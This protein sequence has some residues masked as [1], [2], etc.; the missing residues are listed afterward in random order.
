MGQLR[1]GLTVHVVKGATPDKAHVRFTSSSGQVYEG[2]AR[3]V[4]LGI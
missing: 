3:F 2:L 4:D 1:A